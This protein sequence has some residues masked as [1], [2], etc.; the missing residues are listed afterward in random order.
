MYRLNEVT[1]QQMT[2]EKAE[3]KMKEKK[4]ENI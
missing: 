3:Q 2:T 1:T 4:K